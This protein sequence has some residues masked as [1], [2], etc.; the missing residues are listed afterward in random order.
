[1]EKSL[2]ELV[3]TLSCEC[4][5]AVYS[6]IEHKEFIRQMAK[7]LDALAKKLQLEHSIAMQESSY[8]GY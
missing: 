7:K 1:M 8:N 4:K 3:Y 2:D 6:N 5:E